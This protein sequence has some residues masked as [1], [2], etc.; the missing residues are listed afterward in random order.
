[1]KWVFVNDLNEKMYELSGLECLDILFWSSLQPL[2]EKEHVIRNM[3][4]NVSQ[5]VRLIMKEC[6]NHISVRVWSLNFET[7][8]YHLV[9]VFA[10]ISEVWIECMNWGWWRPCFDC[11]SYL[12]KKLTLCLND[13][14][15]APSL[16][17]MND[18]L[19]E[20][21]AYTVLDFCYLVLGFRRASSIENFGSRQ[22]CP[23]FGGDT[24]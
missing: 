18:W 13:L 11:D 7:N 10:W 15:L 23:K 24:R 17:W 1:M 12:A 3:T 2:E 16:S 9:L 19:I 5:F 21:W 8:D 20:P 4:E 22:I 14:S 6:I